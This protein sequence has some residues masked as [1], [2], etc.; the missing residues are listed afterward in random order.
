MHHDFVD[1]FIWRPSKRAE[2]RRDLGLDSPA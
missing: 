2:P 1:Q